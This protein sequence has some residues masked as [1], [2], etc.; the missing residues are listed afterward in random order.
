[1]LKF[2]MANTEVNSIKQNIR[3]LNLIF[4]ARFILVIISKTRQIQGTMI[5]NN[6]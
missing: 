1:M 6:L 5:E 4:F 2:F 3:I